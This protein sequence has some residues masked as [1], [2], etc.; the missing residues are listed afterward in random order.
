[1]E[2]IALTLKDP[3]SPSTHDLRVTIAPNRIAAA[4]GYRGQVVGWLTISVISASREA[5]RYRQALNPD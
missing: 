3:I 5:H 4:D 1:M 2:G